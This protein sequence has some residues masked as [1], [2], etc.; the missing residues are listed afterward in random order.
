MTE[1]NDHKVTP[2]EAEASKTLPTS[3]PSKKRKKWSDII[4][5]LGIFILAPIIAIFLTQ[6]VFQSY[7]VDG[8]SM[9]TTLQDRDRLIVTKTGKTWSRITGKDYIPKRYEIVIFNYH[10][11]IDR[12]GQSEEKPLIKR[13]IGL[14]GD[15]VLVKDGVVKVF[16]DE[17]PEGYLVDRFGPENEAITITDRNVDMTVQKGHVFVMGDNRENSL[18]SRFFGPVKSEDLIGKLNL[19]I[20]PFDKTE[21]F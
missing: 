3:K 15:R 4:S 6:F 10:G 20:Y 18:D 8:P 14:P 2:Q 11:E 5:T 9:E 7:E 17:H 1:I 19:R 21:R 12:P 16:N 13:V